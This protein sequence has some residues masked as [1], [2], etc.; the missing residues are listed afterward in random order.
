M[1]YYS[2]TDLKKGQHFYIISLIVDKIYPLQVIDNYINN[3]TSK[4]DLFRRSE[5]YV[6][7]RYCRI[8]RKEFIPINSYYLP[9]HVEV[10]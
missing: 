9:F 1:N 3:I 10:L 7:L 4:S 5:A 6:V 2:W 8:S